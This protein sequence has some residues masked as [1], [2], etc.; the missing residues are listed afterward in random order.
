MPSSKLLLTIVLLVACTSSRA[1]DLETFQ[2]L[3]PNELRAA[4][5]RMS[6]FLEPGTARLLR[7]P[8]NASERYLVERQ[9]RH[10]R[11]FNRRA[12]PTRL[13][14]G[15]QVQALFWPAARASR[16]TVGPD[17]R[18]QIQCQPAQVLLGQ[19]L[20]DFRSGNPDVRPAR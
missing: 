14:G 3:D 9:Q 17:G 12:L 7:E 10:A 15:E 1:F 6:E 8:R 16:V 11:Q 13:D 19:V 5:A 18:A 2:S 20:P 4:E